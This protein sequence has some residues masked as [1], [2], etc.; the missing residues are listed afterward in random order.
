MIKNHEDFVDELLAKY[1][2]QNNILPLC[3]D[4]DKEISP[5]DRC[6]LEND[7]VTTS[8]Y[9]ILLFK[10]LNYICKLTCLKVILCTIKAMWGS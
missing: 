9:C 6:L 1:Y 8:F 4:E 5:N 3:T 10:T 7:L 2:D